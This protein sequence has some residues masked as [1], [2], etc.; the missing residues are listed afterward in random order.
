MLPK[1]LFALQTLVEEVC[2]QTD[3]AEL[4]LKVDLTSNQLLLY[5]A[6]LYNSW[7]VI[8]LDELFCLG[9]S[10]LYARCLLR[11]K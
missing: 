6:M 3:I 9:S 7:T 1:L 2:D 4:K 10:L 5:F 8:I 11:I